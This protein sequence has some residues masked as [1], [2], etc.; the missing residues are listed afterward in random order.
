[1]IPKPP[2][3]PEHQIEFNGK[4]YSESEFKAYEASPKYKRDMF[5]NATLCWVLIGS[6][7]M[8]FIATILMKMFVK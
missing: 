2:K 1:M 6:I 3:F 5:W 7:A 4:F 8:A